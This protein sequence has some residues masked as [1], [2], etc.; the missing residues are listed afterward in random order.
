MGA[1][2]QNAPREGT[3]FSRPSVGRQAGRKEGGTQ[4]AADAI[5]TIG[6][7]LFSFC[8]VLSISG[9]QMGLALMLA[10]FLAQWRDVGRAARSEPL[11][12]IAGCWILYMGL[13]AL[14]GVSAFPATAG[15]QLHQARDW[16]LLSL[17]LI[18]A[19]H[20]KASLSR[21]T[22]A[23]GLF[24]LG[25]ALR[26]VLHV[27][28]DNL[29]PF[30]AGHLRDG[31]TLGFGLRQISFS[32]YLAVILIW[33][34]VFAPRTWR[35][36]GA[37]RT[38]LIFAGIA[39][40]VALLAIEG[41]II[42]SSRGTWLA[43]L[44]AF[45]TL[46]VRWKPWLHLNRKKVSISV[47]TAVVLLTAVVATHGTNFLSRA[48][49]DREVYAQILDGDLAETERQFTSTGIRVR[50]WVHGLEKWWS[51]PILG[52][53]A[54]SERM[55]LEEIKPIHDLVERKAGRIPHSHNLLIELLMRFGVA[56]ALLFLAFP[57]LIFWR[58]RTLHRQGALEH[59]VYSFFFAL[60]VFV[61]VWSMFDIRI[62][63]WDYRHFVFVFFGMATSLAWS[64]LRA[65][66]RSPADARSGAVAK[67][68]VAVR[69]NDAS[70]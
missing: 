5:G 49:I 56:G 58:L 70:P 23:A 44:V 14:V 62:M 19:W 13:S 41:I 43:T 36:L 18:A 8:A 6:L 29:G 31:D 60:F 16:A 61:T 26:I 66:A 17:A 59:D 15:H 2:E 28:W 4:R 48:T 1:I 50:M 42:G 25:A 21:F 55:L 20:F 51:R 27:P 53:G 64:H 35:Q 57:A 46:V 22:I 24:T 47:V 38:R 32:S 34:A 7:Y 54:G 12:W 39:V 63:R 9:A 65:S 40:V 33:I 69:T 10:S 11:A 45:A 52:W 30:L 3:G 68:N 67:R 37:G